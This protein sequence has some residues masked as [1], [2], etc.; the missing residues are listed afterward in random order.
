MLSQLSTGCRSISQNISRLDP[1]RVNATHGFAFF[2]RKNSGTEAQGP[3]LLAAKQLKQVSNYVDDWLGYANDFDELLSNLTA[4]LAVCLEDN[5]TLNTSK[6]KFGFSSAQFFGF[7]VDI[8]GTR[9][10]DKH[11][12]PIR[13]RH[14]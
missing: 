14:I 1:Y 6:T 2:G 10:A 13:N 12:C 8:K 3:Y 11:L 5:I 7:K 4:F 9:L